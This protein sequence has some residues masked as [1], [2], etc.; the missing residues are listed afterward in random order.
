MAEE[1]E[2]PV[3]WC[4]ETPAVFLDAAWKFDGEVTEDDFTQGQGFDAPTGPH[5]TGF[6]LCARVKRNA[7]TEGSGRILQKGDP[8]QGWLFAAPDENGVV[9]FRAAA[10]ESR[11]RLESR[12]SQGEGSEVPASTDERAASSAGGEKRIDD[13]E[14]HHVAVVFRSEGFLRVFVDGIP[15]G[16]D[17]AMQVV[18]VPEF[19]LELGIGP[20]QTAT[21]IK[22]VQAFSDALSDAQIF[23]LA[24]NS[25]DL[26][27]G[28]C[29]AMMPEEV[30]Q[31]QKIKV[32][33]GDAEEGSNGSAARELV[34]SALV[35]SPD[36]DR[37]VQFEV[38]CSLYEDLLR[39]AQSICLTPRKTAVMVA[40]LRSILSL[41]QTRSKTTTCVGEPASISECFHEY[42]R[43]LLAHTFA[44]ATAATAQK[45]L[46]QDPD[47]SIATLGV[48]TLPEVRLLTE[49]M[50]GTLF[51]HFL[52]YQCVLVCPQDSLLKLVEVGL[53]R[54]RAPPD[55]RT[56]KLLANRNVVAGDK[57]K[58][59]K[60]LSKSSTGSLGAA[61]AEALPPTE[62]EPP[63]L[64]ETLAALPKGLTVEE[65]AA[66]VRVHGESAVK[67]HD[68][69]LPK[70]N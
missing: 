49:F 18:P 22:D 46:T 50:T 21:D 33:P 6:T 14:W 27:T 13:G 31:Y 64:Q 34:S 11:P 38:T 43:L 63:D 47:P 51:Q 35:L 62:V 54:P 44:A 20:G 26:C 12:Q 52:L 16:D 57:K 19:P 56:G 10:T 36:A 3:P 60:D 58:A 48:F 24:T 32:E 37:P 68:E 66:K 53:E 55:L 45:D 2:G 28:I 8:P 9:S 23:G 61:V 15:D 30:V 42:K 7:D 59:K 4:V 69:A 25:K 70:P 41:M 29:L 65:H 40:I 1:Q 67:R 17:M 39:Y 5:V